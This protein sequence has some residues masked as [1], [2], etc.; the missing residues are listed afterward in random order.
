M[1]YKSKY[2]AEIKLSNKKGSGTASS[3]ITALNYLDEILQRTGLF[4]LGGFWN[5]TS[6]EVVRH[7]YQFALENQKVEGGVFLDGIHAPSYGRGGYYTAALRS[8]GQFLAIQQYEDRLW[9]VYQNDGLESE[10]VVARLTA[11]AVESPELL[12]DDKEWDFTTKEG[13]DALR[14]AK[15]RV[16]QD[17]FRK[18][19]LRQYGT[20]CCVCG[21]NVPEVLR[22][23]HITG[24]AED[25]E[26]RMNPANGL[27]LSATYD[28]AFDK[29][30]I[31]F[32]EEY[33]MILSPSLREYNTNRAFN[34]HF[35]ALEGRRLE[36]PTRYQP[37]RGLLEKHRAQLVA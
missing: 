7:L 8:F 33:R 10:R 22:A 14:R 26:N 1:N 29:H 5:V 9:D 17:F 6:V 16:G 31:S 20:A 27:C 24:W 37:D 12:V 3:Y 34:D 21:L 28:A 35:L 25:R 19:I 18:M 13:K 36:L 30:L 15:A 2:I 11:D 4:G 23:S 32:D